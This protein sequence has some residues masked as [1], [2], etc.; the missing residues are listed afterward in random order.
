MKGKKKER[1]RQGQ[2]S[3]VI[4]L[5]RFVRCTLPKKGC[6]QRF[7]TSGK[8]CALVIDF[9]ATQVIHIV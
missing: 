1:V 5:H 6:Q 7:A 4:H 8:F 9:Q 3:E 2:M